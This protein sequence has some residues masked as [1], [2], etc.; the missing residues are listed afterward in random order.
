MADA[1]FDITDELRLCVE[2]QIPII[3]VPGSPVCDSLIKLSSGD[4]DGSG[5]AELRE[6]IDKGHFFYCNSTNS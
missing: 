4:D 3:V 1:P 5:G 6:L 2:N